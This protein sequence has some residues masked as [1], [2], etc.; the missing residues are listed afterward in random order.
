MTAVQ[1][2]LHALG[3]DPDASAFLSRHLA[4]GIALKSLNGDASTRRYFRAIDAGYLVME[5]RKAP[6]PFASF[7]RLS[8]HLTALGLSAPQV[9]AHSDAHC[10]ALLEDFGAS[11][12]GRLLADG[13]DEHALY[14]LAVSTLVH[15]HR[16]SA[17]THVDVPLFSIERLLEELSVFSNWF[18]PLLRPDLNVETFDHAFR[19]VWSDALMRLPKAPQTLVLRDFHIDNLIFL[20]HREG[21]RRCGLLDFQDALIGAPEY[22]LVSLLQDARRELAEGLEAKMFEQYVS[23]LGLSDVQA[24]EAQRRYTV[25][26]AQR[27]TRIAGVFVRLDQRDGKPGYLRFL[28]RVLRQMQAALQSAQLQDIASFLDQELP[29]WRAIGTSIN[30]G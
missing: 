22:D 1:H 15:L 6:L 8:A 25:L 10:V 28:P 26:G 20:Q 14:Q 19:G 29:G 5:D 21:V 24:A 13:Y 3:F 23:E 2:K 12:Y 9:Y 7:V 11:T 27:H 4:A 17:A 18:A 16:Q 30:T